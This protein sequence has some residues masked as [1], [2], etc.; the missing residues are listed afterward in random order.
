[1]NRI[2][3]TTPPSVKYPGLFKFYSNLI[4]GDIF[5]VWRESNTYTR[6]IIYQSKTF[7]HFGEF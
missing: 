7:F 4:E 3:R 2:F 5:S 6:H 1:M